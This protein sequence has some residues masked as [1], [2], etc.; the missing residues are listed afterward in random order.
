[1]A[2]AQKHV[3]VA[4][5]EERVVAGLPAQDVVAGA[6]VEFIIAGA[7]EHTI[8]A[9]V[10]AQGIIPRPAQE[11][12]VAAPAGK[13]VHPVIPFER[14]VPV[15]AAQR[16][17]VGPANQRIV[18]GLAIE[19]IVARATFQNIVAGAAIQAVVAL[20]AVK[21][22]VAVPGNKPVLARSSLQQVIVGAVL[23]A[24]GRR[25]RGRRGRWWWRGRRHGRD[26]EM[27]QP[28]EFVHR[29]GAGR[30]GRVIG[31]GQP[32]VLAA[33]GQDRAVR[34]GADCD[35]RQAVKP[36][37]RRQIQPVLAGGEVDDVVGLAIGA[38]HEQ[39]VAAAAAQGVGSGPV[40]Q[41]IVAVP[42]VEMVI[43]RAARHQ[44]HVGAAGQ[45]VGAGAAQL[46]R[47][48]PAGIDPKLGDSGLGLAAGK[49][50]NAAV[51]HME[52]DCGDVGQRGP[53]VIGDRGQVHEPPAG[54]QR[55]QRQPVVT[56]AC[57]Q[58]HPSV[59]RHRLQRGDPGK[60]GVEAVDDMVG[61]AKPAIG[62]KLQ[63]A[64]R[65]R[66][67]GGQHGVMRPVHLDRGKRRGGVDA[68]GVPCAQAVDTDRQPG[69]GLEPI[70]GDGVVEGRGRQQIG[71]ATDFDRRDGDDVGA[72]RPVAAAGLTD[73]GQPLVGAD[74]V[75]GQPG[76]APLPGIDQLAAA[77]RD[78][79]HRH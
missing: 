53:G 55:E 69:L 22:I 64:E 39:I 2:P 77:K 12:V 45:R 9:G 33:K 15:A 76:R 24:A 25:R 10:T 56:A 78:A 27:H 34:G 49:N 40:H 54:Q 48:Q 5:A 70:A 46:R 30:Q 31:A 4:A 23:P 63:H 7:A 52:R 3:R 62:G 35:L 79:F 37:D 17:A 20:G 50:V 38:Q 74:L 21:R 72:L 32:Q 61:D 59:Y 28:G 6:A 65:A 13:I 73:L 66:A 67:G 29:E 71:P 58:E 47:H 11:P 36:P 43:S 57:H 41:D 8:L 18:A 1:M 44:I 26:I 14:V 75:D 60:A 19:P 51:A 42:A 16:V 68:Q